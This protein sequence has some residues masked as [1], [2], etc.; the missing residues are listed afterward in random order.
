M[1]TVFS[2]TQG[3]VRVAIN[4]WGTGGNTDYSPIEPNSQDSW[5]RVD[6][7]GFVMY[8]IEST[9]QDGPYYVKAG[10]EVKI[11]SSGVSG[12]IKIR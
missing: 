9:S 10:S 11:S 3:V 8:V 5:D 4:Q 12:A 2:Q 1:I 6:P 7:R